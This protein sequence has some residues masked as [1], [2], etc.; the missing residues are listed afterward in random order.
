MEHNIQG[1]QWYAVQVAAGRERSVAEMLRPKGYETFVP[2]Y[3][4]R[5]RW[6]DRY[7]QLATALFPGYLF[8]KFDWVKRLSV[9]MTPRVRQIVGC[10]RQPSPVPDV[11]IDSLRIAMAS[12]VKAGPHPYLVP[13]QTVTI[14]EGPL[15]GI[16]GTLLQVKD[17][18]HLVISVE[19]LQRA[20]SVEL[21]RSWVETGV[22]SIGGK[23]ISREYDRAD[24][25]STLAR[26]ARAAS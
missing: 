21:D 19:V 20:M 17:L 2:S 15:A 8:A 5:R 7:K 26:S 25:N 12:G 10:G 14:T 3:R 13:G 11:E 6:S 22:S 1:E 9:I 4:S 16:T 23:G 18:F 24:G